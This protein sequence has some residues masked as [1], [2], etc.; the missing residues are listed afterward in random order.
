MFSIRE[1]YLFA[2]WTALYGAYEASALHRLLTAAGRWCN[3]RIDESRFLGVLCREGTVARAW[4]GSGTCRILSFLVNLPGN[5]LHRLYTAFQRQFDQ[6]IFAGLAFAM[7]DE[8]AIGESWVIMALWIIPFER[9]NNAYNLLG[10]AVLLIL[11]YAGSMRR[12]D[13]F[14][15]DVKSVGPYAVG[16]FLAVVLGV[17]LSAYPSLSARFLMYHSVCLLCVLVTVSAVRNTG[18]LKRLAAGGSAVVLVS[19][20][21]AVIQRIQGVEVN[22]SYVDLD[23]NAGMPGR[24]ESFF[25]NPN[26][27]AQVLILLL[28]IVLGLMLCAR[29]PAFKAAAAGIFVVGAGALGMTYS[30][31]SWVGIAAAMAMAVFLWRPKLIP[32]F[33]AGCL[34]VIPLLPSSILN[35]IQSI[36]NTSDTSTSGRIPLYQAALATIGKSPITG[37][38]LGTAAVQQF[39]KDN[40][41]YH[42]RAPF[43]HAHD[44]YLQVWIEAGLL[45]VVSFVGAMLLNIK[46]AAR[47][48]RHCGES[49]ARTL[50]CAA[51][52]SLCGIMVCGLA[53]YPWNYPRVMSI[54]WFVFA[55]CIAGTKLCH[56]TE[57]KEESR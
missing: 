19:S 43:V 39:I 3:R 47:T 31:A 35:R 8:T 54:F 36:T 41:L 25:D 46:N 53:D 37:A 18:D 57:Q 32:L 55:L 6:S 45:G 34:L 38:G 20:L 13:T 26:T 23:V 49:A 5:L 42:A 21:Y 4:S 50:T 29:R 28:P 2:F 14:R 12:Y 16:M 17:V 24:V 52:S 1:S 27:F 33:A 10:F 11:F 7:G 56:L 48:V 15:L 30:R 9:W 40:N 22:R 51:A 44:I